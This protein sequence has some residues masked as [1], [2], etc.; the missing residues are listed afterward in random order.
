MA[1]VQHVPLFLI[2]PQT[3]SQCY[4]VDL[5]LIQL[6]AFPMINVALESFLGE[7]KIVGLFSCS[8]K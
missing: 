5:G 7:N 4:K 3:A 6:C 1:L 2:Y 8:R